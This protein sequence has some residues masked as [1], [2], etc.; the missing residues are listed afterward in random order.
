MISRPSIHHN[1]RMAK[2]TKSSKETPVSPQTKTRGKAPKTHWEKVKTEGDAK[3]EVN[4]ARFHDESR[5]SVT[6][7]KETEKEKDTVHCGAYGGRK[8][9]NDTLGKIL[10]GFAA[11]GP[12]KASGRKSNNLSFLT[13]QIND[14]GLGSWPLQWLGEIVFSLADDP[15][16]LALKNYATW[17]LEH[18]AA[19]D[20]HR[21]NLDMPPKPDDCAVCRR[22]TGLLDRLSEVEDWLKQGDVLQAIWIA[23]EAGII[24]SQLMASEQEWAARYGQGQV[25]E[26]RRRRLE[27]AQKIEEYETLKAQHPKLKKTKIIEMMSGDRANNMRVLK[28]NGR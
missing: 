2:T 1:A 28:Q 25:E 4:T 17:E 22:A 6:T 10:H 27:S 21:Q 9:F 13:K 14:A 5:V 24:A 19:N 26:V 23:V 3:V 8:Y 20:Y 7:E 12:Y 16:L 15:W 11:Q 18:H